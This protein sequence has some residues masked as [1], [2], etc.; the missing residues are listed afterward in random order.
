MFDRGRT[1]TPHDGGFVVEMVSVMWDIPTPTGE[2]LAKD[3]IEHRKEVG[4]QIF[5]RKGESPI[6]EAGEKG[7]GRLVI[8][9]SGC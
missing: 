6:P 5:S 9:R 2:V 1:R 7:W 8:Q 3:E 4:L